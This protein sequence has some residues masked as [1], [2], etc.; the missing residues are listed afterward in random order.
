M[1]I[2]VA[3]KGATDMMPTKIP[4]TSE[5]RKRLL[6]SFFDLPPKDKEMLYRA[7]EHLRYLTILW[8]LDELDPD[9][10]PSVPEKRHILLAYKLLQILWFNKLPERGNQAFTIYVRDRL[11]DD[12]GPE[13]INKAFDSSAD[14][15]A[16]LC[17]EMPRPKWLKNATA[18]KT[19]IESFP[20][21]SR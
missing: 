11:P 4:I 17:K 6:Q 12:Q 20:Q 16:D 15:L 19:S 8:G 7:V 5:E 1:L 14:E 21:R 2:P 9:S 18:V 13:R 3:Q 10:M